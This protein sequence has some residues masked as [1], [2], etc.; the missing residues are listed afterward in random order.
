[1]V[2][3]F[4]CVLLENN[5]FGEDKRATPTHHAHHNCVYTS[6]FFDFHLSPRR[7]QARQAKQEEREA[8]QKERE[9]KKKVDL[10]KLADVH[11]SESVRA[12]VSA[13]IAERLEAKLSA[14]QQSGGRSVPPTTH[15]HTH[16][17]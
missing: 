5:I 12:L 10:E 8:K 9:V 11:M 4:F 1:M 16:A 13:A 3:H 17:F 6:F 7:K 14:H 2:K 15:T